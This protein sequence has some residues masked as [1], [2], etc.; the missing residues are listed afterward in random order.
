MKSGGKKYNFMEPVGLPGRRHQELMA[1][2]LSVPWRYDVSRRSAVVELV[3]AHTKN[4]GGGRD[5]DPGR[6]DIRLGSM[7]RSGRLS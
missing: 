5:M 2:K 4:A 3:Q 1:R 6:P 7:G